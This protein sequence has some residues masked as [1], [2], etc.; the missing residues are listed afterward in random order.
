VEQS[1]AKSIASRLKAAWNA[2]DMKEFEDLCRPQCRS[3]LNLQE[4]YQP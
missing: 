1:E 2:H 3:F 4:V